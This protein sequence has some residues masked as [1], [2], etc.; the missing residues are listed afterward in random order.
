MVDDWLKESEKENRED[1]KEKESIDE[2][3]SEDEENNEENVKDNK[4]A[5]NNSWYSWSLQI[6][7]EVLK[8]LEK[9]K[10]NCCNAED[11][12]AFHM[13]AL[14]DSLL[15]HMRLLPLWS[16]ILTDQFGFGRVPATSSPSEGDFNTLKN[17]VFIHENKLPLRVDSFI[18]KHLD[19][20]EGK[21]LIIDDAM[22][23]MEKSIV[24]GIYKEKI[25]YI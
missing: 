20:L 6:Q 23:Q 14:G 22:S 17:N 3:E 11:N 13:P 1:E 15:K 21:M 25:L 24:E 2:E 5:H 18:Q 19:Y 9:E 8:V 7:E 4:N 16:N 12:M 10:N